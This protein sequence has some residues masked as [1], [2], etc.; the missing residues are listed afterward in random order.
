MHKQR[1]TEKAMHHILCK[2]TKKHS[3]GLVCGKV[4]RNAFLLKH[5]MHIAWFSLQFSQYVVIRFGFLGAIT[6]P[7][8]F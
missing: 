7:S 1:K 5:S 6:D 8:P 3:E 2:K 4:F